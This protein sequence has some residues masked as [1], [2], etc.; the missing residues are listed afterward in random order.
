[1][2]EGGSYQVPQLT[3]HP[4]HAPELQSPGTWFSFPDA[5]DDSYKVFA[6][7]RDVRFNENG[8]RGARRGRSR[9]ACVKC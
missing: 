8:I 6:N 3:A 4:S 5:V 1:M 9:P 2:L 7:V